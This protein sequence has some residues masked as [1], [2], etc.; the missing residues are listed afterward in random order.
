MARRGSVAPRAAAVGDR[1]SVLLETAIAIPVLL[2]IAGA[3]AWALS[4]ATTSLTLQ[5]AARQVARDVARGIDSASAVA[6]AERAFPGASITVTDVTDAVVVVVTRDVAAPVP[7]LSGL[8]VPLRQ[9]LS[10]P[11]EW[12]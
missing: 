11:R 8:T 2:V 6:G 12:E 5:E 3:L 4:L 10:M 1:G 7:L 9:E